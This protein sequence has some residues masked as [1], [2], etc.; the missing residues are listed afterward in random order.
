MAELHATTVRHTVGRHHAWGLFDE[1]H[2][3]KDAGSDTA[4]EAMLDQLAHEVS[5]ARA[6][7]RARGRAQ[8]PRDAGT[9]R[10]YAG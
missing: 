10:P 4:A 3:R 2:A 5:P 7:P 9:A 6:K 8:A 1:T